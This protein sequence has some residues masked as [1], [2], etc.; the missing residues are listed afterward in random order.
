[1]HVL[2][3]AIVQTALLF[4]ATELLNIYC[5]VKVLERN[6][7]ISH[8]SDSARRREGNFPLLPQTNSNLKSTDLSRQTVKPGGRIHVGPTR[9]S[10]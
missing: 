9:C 3:S 7:D 1:M 6:Y 5:L 4:R 2:A 8:G 10:V